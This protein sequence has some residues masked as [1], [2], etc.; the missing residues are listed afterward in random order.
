MCNLAY[1]TVKRVKLQLN[2]RENYP[3]SLRMFH[4]NFPP[5]EVYH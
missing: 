5:S 3:I 4:L 2:I 1:I